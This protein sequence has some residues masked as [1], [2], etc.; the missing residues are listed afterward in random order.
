LNSATAAVAADSGSL[1]AHALAN[2][3]AKMKN[4]EF[5]F[6]VRRKLIASDYRNH[7]QSRRH[8]MASRLFF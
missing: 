2:S 8:F 3:M 5:I 4:L 6:Q 7:L 1:H